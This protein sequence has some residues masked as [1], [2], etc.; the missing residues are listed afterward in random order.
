[1]TGIKIT[2]EAVERALGYLKNIKMV[3]KRAADNA[4]TMWAEENVKVV[5]A[6]QFLA[7]DSSKSVAEREHIARASQAH[8]DAL[9]QYKA[10]VETDKANREMVSTAQLILDLYRTESANARKGF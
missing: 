7:A 10:C 9:N 8:K 1:M 6:E 4:Q 5:R 3:Q 2:D